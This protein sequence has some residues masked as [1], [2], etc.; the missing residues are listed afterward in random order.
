MNELMSG[1]MSGTKIHGYWTLFFGH[2]TDPIFSR[3]LGE[4]VI[5]FLRTRRSRFRFV[6][7]FFS[8][9]QEFDF[10]MADSTHILRNW[11]VWDRC[12]YHW[13]WGE[14]H[15]RGLGMYH[16]IFYIWCGVYV[17]SPSQWGKRSWDIK[18]GMG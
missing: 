10:F 13:G 5:I 12:V 4:I 14:R 11:C 2:P 3:E 9:M 15:E 8:E 16:N 1:K 18:L 7:K 17:I 6:K